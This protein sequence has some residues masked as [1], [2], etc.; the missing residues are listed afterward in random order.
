MSSHTDPYTA[1][2]PRRG[3]RAEA[4]LRSAI[5]L[6]RD[7]LDD[8]RRRINRID[9]SAQIQRHPWRAVGIALAIG[10]VAG[11]RGRR[12]TAAPGRSLGGMAVGALGAIGLHVLRELAVAHLGRSARRW[13]SE[14]GGPPFDEDDALH[15]ANIDP[16]LE[17]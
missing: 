1:G 8:A 16:F 11:R 7:K 10:A 17:R 4:D 15:R 5:D 13:W 9:L 2:P 3:E 6:L 12:R 14:H